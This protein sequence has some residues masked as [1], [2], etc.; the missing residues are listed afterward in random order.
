MSGTVK[1]VAV[2]L[3]L[4]GADNVRTQ[5]TAVGEAG[6][7][8]MTSVQN[9]TNQA[10]QS[11][12]RFNQAV[13]QGG[14]QLQDFAVQVQGGTSALTA[15]AQQGSQF[16]GIFGPGGAIA[17]AVLAV[18]AL[19]ASFL[20]I[21]DNAERE[22]KRIEANF[23]GMQQAGQDVARVIREINELF[24]TASERSAAAA[25]AQR[26]QLAEDARRLLDITTQRN[27]GNVIE[28]ADAA[29]EVERRQR[30]LQAI[31][32]ANRRAGRDINP[33]STAAAT[34]ALG[35]AEA[36]VAEIERDISR[37]SARIGELNQALRRAENAGVAGPEEFGPPAPDRPRRDAAGAAASRRL[38]TAETR[39]VNDAIRDRDQL[40]RSIETPQERY[41]RRLEELQAVQLRLAESGK[42]LNDEQLS[43]V[44]E[45]LQRELD[46]ASRRAEGVDKTGR[47]LGLTF[48]SA[49]ED[50]IVKGKDF[51]E[52]LK[53]IE[54]DIARIILRRAVTEPLGDALKGLN[55][56][57]IFTALTNSLFGPRAN[58]NWAPSV[59]AVGPFQNALGNAFFGG[60]VIPFA[61]GGIVGGPTFFPMA[62]GRTGLMG[63]AG[64]EAIMPLGR[65]SSGR[66]GVRAQGGGMTV[67]Q[68]FTIDARGADAGVDAKI[69]AGIAIA[70]EQ[71]NQK[72]LAQINRGGSVAKTVG[73]RA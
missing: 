57:G 40:L 18:G 69:R 5:L 2:R 46:E 22:Q 11:T 21:G 10:T 65:D 54:A 1:R 43:R 49:F 44:R 16:L 53:G 52:V 8:S 71:A 45:G 30:A 6:N 26:Q 42:Q 67:N 72:L 55:V 68:N 4:E 41:N 60:Q 15:L 51:R 31:E 27:E 17:G 19:A 62:G 33:G 29:R 39:E 56:G 36:R 73:R 59:S 12:G 32:A 38:A 13:V 28:R 20:T 63:E 24:L 7:R 25:N 66:L 61:A 3:A 50:A 35:Q 58:P 34:A 48:S 9:A 23:R 64:P 37:Q 14:F 70:V 47:E